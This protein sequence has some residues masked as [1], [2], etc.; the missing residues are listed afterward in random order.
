MGTGQTAKKLIAFPWIFL[1]RR[2]VKNLFRIS[3]IQESR[4]L[5]FLIMI[6]FK[7]HDHKAS[8]IHSSIILKQYGHT[9]YWQSGRLTDWLTESQT[10]Q[11]TLL[12][13]IFFSYI[14]IFLS[15]FLILCCVPN[16]LFLLL[17]F[18]ISKEECLN[19]IFF[20]F[21]FIFFLFISS[22]KNEC[23]FFGKIWS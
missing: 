8:F 19:F 21:F 7:Q 22:K 15:E 20:Q 2:S 1:C 3:I 6:F 5:Y 14:Q 13:K 17:L 4:L 11:P 10:D 9:T 12:S 23:Y 18:Y 16:K